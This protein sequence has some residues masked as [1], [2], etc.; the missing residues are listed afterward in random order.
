[1]VVYYLWFKCRF[2][3]R[4]GEGVTVLLLHFGDVNY[5]L[6]FSEESELGRVSSCIC[7]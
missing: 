2:V 5:K 7:E 3:V 4:K 6:M 1:M